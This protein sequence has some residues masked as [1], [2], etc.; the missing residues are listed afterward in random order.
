MSDTPTPS[1][2]EPHNL[3]FLKGWH[4]R[5][6]E[7]EALKA[8]CDI[9]KSNAEILGDRLMRSDEEV[10]QLRAVAVKICQR[11]AELESHLTKKEKQ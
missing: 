11:V 3:E 9:F 8:R 10:D 6:A 5:D 7:V 1:Q 2:N 4:S